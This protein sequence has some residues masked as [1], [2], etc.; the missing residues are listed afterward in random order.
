MDA[1][2]SL[3]QAESEVVIQITINNPFGLKSID[4]YSFSRE[5]HGIILASS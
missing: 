2:F 5:L 1:F 4:P 3:M